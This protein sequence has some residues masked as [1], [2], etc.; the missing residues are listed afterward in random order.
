M[1]S[2]GPRLIF[3]IGLDEAKRSPL[4]VTMSRRVI[5]RCLSLLAGLFLTIAVA[6][7]E[8]AVEPGMSRSQVI[9]A[10]GDPASAMSRGSIEVFVYS[11]GAKITLHD[12]IVTEA[13][14]I[15]LLTATDKE[16]TTEKPATTPAVPNEEQAI[17]KAEDAALAQQD[18]D[19]RAKFEQALADL[20]ERQKN[21]QSQLAPRKFNLVNFIAGLLIKTLITLLALKLTSKYWGYEILWSGIVIAAVVDTVVRT[22]VSMTGKILLGMP[23]V[24][25]ADEAVAAIVMVLVVK[26]VST[27]QSLNQA[28][29]IT[30][31]TKV[32]T[33]VAGSF[34]VTMLL[35]M[36]S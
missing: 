21:P 22:A 26:K 19:Q 36:I 33:I 11:D 23:T 1:L 9:Q 25:Y 17:L 13:L 6:A 18:A 32:F 15:P 31:T 20:E 7:Q 12:G 24:F 10:L 27:S 14:G 28:I 29:Q 4:L 16:A 2:E 5:S 3:T 8:L 30:L 34:L 35:Q